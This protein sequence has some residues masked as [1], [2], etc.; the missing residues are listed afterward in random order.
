VAVAGVAMRARV[1]IE[2]FM[3]ILCFLRLLSADFGIYDE[4]K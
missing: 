3:V 2:N 1:A 4:K